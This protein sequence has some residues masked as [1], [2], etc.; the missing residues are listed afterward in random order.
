M[1]LGTVNATP[2][3]MAGVYSTFVNR[4]VYRQPHIV[5]RVEQ[6]NDDGGEPTCSTSARPPRTG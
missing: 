4:G 6:V 1:V 2:L 5:T 3:E